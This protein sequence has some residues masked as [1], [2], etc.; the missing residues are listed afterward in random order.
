MKWMTFLL[1]KSVHL[2]MKVIQEVT[3]VRHVITQIV[4]IQIQPFFRTAKHESAAKPLHENSQKTALQVIAERFATYTKH[5]YFS[6]KLE[7]KLF[8]SK[9]KR[10]LIRLNTKTMCRRCSKGSM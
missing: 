2:R 8:S 5:A 3:L 9:A 6:C 10:E 4:V 1:R 7:S